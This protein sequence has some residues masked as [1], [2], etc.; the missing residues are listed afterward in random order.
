MRKNLFF[1]IV[2]LFVAHVS[3]YAGY[4]TGFSEVLVAS[5]ITNPTIM[6]FAPDGR[7][8]VAQQSGALRIIKNG[9][10]LTKP[11]ITLSVN[12]SGERGLLGIAFDPNFAANNFIYLYYTLSSA[13]NNR[14]SRFT[15]SGDTVI[16][17]SEVVVLN[18]DP[19]STATNHNGGTMAF[20]PDGKLYVGV[21]ENA[22]SANAQNLDTYLGKILRINSDGSVPAGNPYTTGTP[23]RMRV[24]EHGMR[25]PYTLT[26]QPGTGKLFVNDVGQSAWEEIN[27]C[28]SG[29]HNYGW[30]TIEGTSSNPNFTNPVFVYGHGSGA[31]VGCAITGGTFFNPPSSSYPAIFTGKY[32]Y[33]DYCSNWISYIN[34]ADSLRTAFA[35]AIAGFPVGIVT[36][37]D[38]NLYFCSR[39]NNAVYKVIYNSGSAPVITNQPQTQTIAQGNPVT[40]SVSVT[41]SNPFTYQWRKNGNNISSA[42]NSS[43]AI[44]SV[45]PGDAGTYSV[46]VTNS[47]GTATSMNASLF[48]TGPNQVPTA[49]ISTPGAGAMYSGGSVISFS[50]S[51]TDPE[52]GALPAS[53][54]QWY[55]E[56]HHDT[57]LHPGPSTP[58]GVASGTF[59]IPNSGETSTNVYYRLFMVVTDS[60]GAKDSAYT[61]ILPRTSTI[62]LNTSPSGLT[63]TLDGQPFTAPLTV[64]SVEGMLRTIGVNSPQ[65]INNA[66]VYNFS[67]W[68]QG[69]SQTQTFA[70]PV[71]NVSYTAN[72]TA[73][74]RLADNPTPTVAGLDYKYYQGTWNI[75]P[76]FNTLA[77]IVTGTVAN[78]DITPALQADNFGFRFTG[79][80]SVPTDGVY[81]FYTTSDDGSNLC[82]GGTAVVKNDSLH[83]AIEKSGQVGLKAGKHPIRVDYFERTGSNVLTVSYAGPG[84]V[85][86]LIPSASLT[87]QPASVKINP[88]ADAFVRSGGTNSNY[89]TAATM[90]CRRQNVGS[91]DRQTYI[92]FDISSFSANISSAK[93]RLYGKMSNTIVSNVPVDVRDVSNTTWGETTITYSNKPAPVAAVSAT[94]VILSTTPQYYEW[95]LTAYLMAKKASGATMITLNLQTTNEI[96]N[97]VSFN[98]KEATSRIPELSVVFS[99]PGRTGESTPAALVNPAHSDAILSDLVVFPNPAHDFISIVYSQQRN[100]SIGIM[101]YDLNGRLEVDN[102]FSERAAGIYTEQM[103]LTALAKGIYI[104]VIQAGEEKIVKRIIVE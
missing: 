75:L 47:F 88:L 27:N 101:I 31:T 55:V 92:R 20:G 52:D 93:L 79:Y 70:T 85:K 87:T 76:D 38:G 77:P 11:F 95:D 84:I 18:L 63:V 42:T 7:L 34:P 24:W 82:V 51:G 35:T 91:N 53:G 2:F 13:A 25:N 10:L 36:G 89:G 50:G 32:F 69:G 46:V 29:G 5:G 97:L 22:N 66:V 86:Q 40:F 58:Q 59:T 90:Y 71:N 54:Y 100:A 3:C 48:V 4:P 72:F 61:D 103:D 60:Q 78:F 73:Q 81:T 39:T 14:I 37:P 1:S 41:G 19:L 30:P 65:T 102:P 15:A 21:G 62:T 56:F 45:V 12:S 104:I 98:T 6:T 94:V 64:T 17:G 26:F 68:S 43:Y 8:F 80:I 83:S 16:P 74:L 99:F 28:T 67:S 9:S 23:Q 49:T 44:A 57:H 33:H 96:S